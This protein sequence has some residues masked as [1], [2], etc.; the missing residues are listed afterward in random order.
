VIRRSQGSLVKALLARVEE[1]KC[2]DQG[3]RWEPVIGG[4]RWCRVCC[5]YEP[6][7]PSRRT[8]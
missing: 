8:A 7:V 3:H 2:A 6:R 1:T 4:G 5:A